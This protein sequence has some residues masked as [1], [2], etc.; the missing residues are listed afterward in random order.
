MA[1]F[2]LSVIAKKDGYDLE[3]TLLMMKERNKEATYPMGDRRLEKAVK[4]AYKKNYFVR[5]EIVEMIFGVRPQLR[6]FYK[7][8]KSK[9]E[10]TY[11]KTTERSYD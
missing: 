1:A 6:G 8:K 2:E 9:D 5:T 4:S 10:R 7:H 3:D 11:E